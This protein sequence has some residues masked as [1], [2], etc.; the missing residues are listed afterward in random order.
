MKLK[1][2]VK[3]LFERI[4]EKRA[5]SGEQ[6]TRTLKEILE[7]V[8]VNLFAIEEDPITGEKRITQDTIRVWINH[9]GSILIG[10]ITA[11]GSY[12]YCG[13]KTMFFRE[14]TALYKLGSLATP[15]SV[16]WYIIM[17]I[18]CSVVALAVSMV[19]S[20]AVHL[21]SNLCL[22]KG[23]E[24]QHDIRLTG[25]ALTCAFYLLLILI[26]LLFQVPVPEAYWSKL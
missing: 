8:K 23:M 24:Y 18:W 17:M 15:P 10:L 6:R 7:V 3:G 12:W 16:L 13:G 1:D 9:V 2:D 25:I 20:G 5:L 14:Q 22:I 21:L 11:L 26:C 4:R 19:I